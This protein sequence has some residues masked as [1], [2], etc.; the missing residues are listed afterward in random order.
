MLLAQFPQIK[1]N[2]VGSDRILFLILLCAENGE[3]EKVVFHPI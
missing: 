3:L 2:F 1:I